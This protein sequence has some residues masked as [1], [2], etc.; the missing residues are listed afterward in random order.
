MPDSGLVYLVSC[1]SQQSER[2]HISICRH[3]RRKA[4][5]AHPTPLLTRAAQ[6]S[7]SRTIEQNIAP[8]VY[9]LP[10]LRRLPL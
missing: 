2:Q 4:G 1:V 6:I 5:P 3:A 10:P 8:T 9:T 7:L